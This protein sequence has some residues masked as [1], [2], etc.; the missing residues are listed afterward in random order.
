ML[1]RLR[2]LQA[3]A[4]AWRP[5]YDVTSSDTATWVVECS[6]AFTHRQLP[7]KAKFRKG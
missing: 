2:I 7:R 4:V 1:R 3:F 6:G 5:A